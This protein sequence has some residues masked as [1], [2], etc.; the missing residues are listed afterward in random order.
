MS[1]NASLCSFA[2]VLSLPAEEPCMQRTTLRAKKHGKKSSIYILAAPRWVAVLLLCAL[3]AVL[4]RTSCAWFTVALGT[5]LGL[6]LPAL[7]AVFRWVGGAWGLQGPSGTQGCMSMQL[8]DRSA[9]PA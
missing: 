6:G 3:S 7:H 5:A 1:K 2:W 4:V 8:S 9:G